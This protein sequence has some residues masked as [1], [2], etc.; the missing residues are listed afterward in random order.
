MLLQVQKAG[1]QKAN[2]RREALKKALAAANMTPSE[3]AHQAGYTTA[4]AIFNFLNERSKSLSQE[5]IERLA[6]VIPGATIASLTGNEAT[7]VPTAAVQG[8]VVRSIAQAGKMRESFDLRKKDQYEELMPIQPGYQRS[9]AFGVQ[10]EAPGAERLFPNGTILVCVPA[11]QFKEPLR[12]GILAIVQRIQGKL[13]EITVKELVVVDGKA[14]L[15]PRSDHP[16]HQAPTMM[17]WPFTNDIWRTDTGRF[18]IT[19]VVIGNYSPRV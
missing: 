13:I 1:K 12:T 14:W 6:R 9:G 18:A 19:A 3:A 15:W 17:P 10:V 5:T 7:S 8:L 16:E 11:P 2:M 4:N